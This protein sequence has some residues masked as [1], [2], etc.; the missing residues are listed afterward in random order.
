MEKKLILEPSM[1]KPTRSDFEVIG[2]FNPAITK[3]QDHFIMI[4]RVAERAI[5]SDPDHYLLPHYEHDKGVCIRKVPRDSNDYD[6]SDCRL[7]KNHEATY[8]TSVSHL[9]I[10][11]SVDGIAFDLDN[12][13]ILFPDNIYEEYGIEDPRI[14]KIGDTYYIT[15]T[16]VSSNGI[17]VRLIKTTDFLS[18]KRLGNIF[19][20]DNKDCVIF[21]EKINGKYF[22]LHR[23][24][25]SQFGRLDI[26]TAQ[27]ENL[28]DWGNHQVLMD[29]R[30]D[31][32]ES[33]RVGGGA[34]P[35]LTDKGWLVIYHSAD[36][37]H[38]YHLTAMLLDLDDPQK[39][40]MRSEKPLIE[41]TE[42]Y[43]KIGFVNDVVFTCG[44]VQENNEVLVYYGACDERVALCKLSLPEIYLNLREVNR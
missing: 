39:V 31:Y 7:V 29:A 18:F 8:L 6:Y 9:R 43:E 36:K 26:W 28:T 25:I 22:A 19:H 14:T 1:L 4:A 13:I 33:I 34:V 21:P 23:P 10:M 16:A 37:K 24:S 41:P 12:A 5:Q 15:F 11:K 32:Q 27:S 35:V 30:I 20:S 38:R 44:L 17:N 2:V 3:Y 42:A 40:L